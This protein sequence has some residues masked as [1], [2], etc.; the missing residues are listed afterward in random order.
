[1]KDIKMEPKVTVCIMTYN[2]EN[3][4]RQCLQS[5]VDQDTEFYFDIIVA[6]DCSTDGT[7]KIVQ[8]FADKY[9]GVV[10]PILHEKNIG[11]FKNFV[12]VH[13]QATGQY[14][15][16]MDGDDYALP[17]KLQAQAE[18]LDLN[19]DISL[20]AHQLMVLGEIMPDERISYPVKANIYDLLKLGCYFGHSSVMYRKDCHFNHQPEFEA[21]DYYFHIEHA[22]KGNIFLDNRVF[23]CHRVHNFGIS[24]DFKYRLAIEQYYEAAFDRAFELGV[25]YDLVQSARLNRRMTFAI[26]RYLS[27]DIHG[28]KEMIKLNKKN[29]SLASPRHI[30]LHYFRWAPCIL[31]MT[32]RIRHFLKSNIL[33]KGIK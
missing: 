9:P 14:V 27:G 1:M 32:I 13:E 31:G 6:D 33:L 3:F 15:A 29:I 8:E 28:F 30:L 7:P 12:F 11:A 17:G 24:Q 20:C 16:H 10:K 19:K 21:I 22:S 25:S 23:G 18:F 4:I 2:Q 5:L 26:S